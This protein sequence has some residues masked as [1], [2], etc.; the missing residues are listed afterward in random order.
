MKYYGK[1]IN[2]GIVASKA[3]V[4]RPYAYDILYKAM[5]DAEENF[6]ISK[7]QK[8][9]AFKNAVEEAKKEL[10]KAYDFLVKDGNTD[11]DILKS[12]IEILS[13]DVMIDDVCTRINEGVSLYYSLIGTFTNYE[14]MFKDSGD[15]RI[16]QRVIDLEDVLRRICRIIGKL[17][18]VSLSDIKD[19][20]VIVAPELFPAD[21][22]RFNR[23]LI[24]AI[25]IENGAETSHT[26]IIAKNLNIPCIIDTKRIC[27]KTI[28]GD[29][30][31]VDCERELVYV[32]PDA[33]IKK[34]YDEDIKLFETKEKEIEKY[35]LSESLTKDK[36]KINISA[37]VGRELDNIDEM[38]KVSDGCGLFRTEFLYIGKSK[39]PSEDELCDI[40]KKVLMAYKDKYVIFRT[41]DVG[42]DKEI[43]ALEIK[44]ENNSFLGERAI[45]YC[46]NHQEVF[47]QELRAIIR[48]SEVSYV[49]LMFPMISSA[50]DFMK[51]KSI[52]YEEREKLVNEGFILKNPIYLGTMIE[53]PSA[54]LNAEALALVSDFA[55]IGTNDLTQYTLAVDRTN[56]AVDCYYK[57]YD[58]AVLKLID[59]TVKAYAKYNKIVGVCGELA[60]DEKITPVFVGMGV[61][62]L[63]MSYGQVQYV[64]HKLAQ[65]NMEECKKI[66]KKVIAVDS[67]K[68]VEVLINEL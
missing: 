64:R 42:G 16:A 7:E 45:R 24:K 9:A 6:Y 57:K 40:Y 17:P 3:Y 46:F 29:D 66:Y 44:K 35:R 63:S 47:R 52:F 30:I 18:R 27:I 38:A 34:F 49:H 11:S 8:I 10:Q 31:I 21:T 53:I 50:E 61:K 22:L 54:A 43:P 48:A 67:A 4:Y 20:C 5:H 32:N 26:S 33:K 2:K 56:D 19:E 28:T 68:E 65:Y 1:S 25:V 58:P 55:S 15:D 23:K 39:L 36:I 59:M 62:E 12:H 37:N 13:D 60:S 51:A 41:L 14:E